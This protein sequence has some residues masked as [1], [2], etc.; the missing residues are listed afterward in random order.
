MEY[1]MNQEAI[2]QL[3]YIAKD[4]QRR[5]LAG[6]PQDFTVLN[7]L[8]SMACDVSAECCPPYSGRNVEVVA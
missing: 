1:K 6:E 2:D 5:Y 4:T 7:N 3:L 8:W